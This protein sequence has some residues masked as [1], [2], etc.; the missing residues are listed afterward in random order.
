MSSLEVQNSTPQSLLPAHIM[1]QDGASKDITNVA[2]LPML[3]SESSPLLRLPGE[4]RNIIYGYVLGGHTFGETWENKKPPQ[5]FLASLLVCRQIYNE[6]RM[7][8][9][10]LNT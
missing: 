9:F 1:T 4:L 6:A 8:V 7:L 3:N 5:H 10:E 2:Q